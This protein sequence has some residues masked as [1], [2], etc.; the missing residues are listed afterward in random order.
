M[1]IKKRKL[2]RWVTGI[3]RQDDTA[4]K[5]VA[6][7]AVD[8]ATKSLRDGV[9]DADLVV[10]ASRVDIILQQLKD[11]KG[12]LKPGAVVIDV[13]STKQEIVST[14]NKSLKKNEFVGC[15]PMAG[16][17]KSGVENG[18]PDLFEGATCVLSKRHELVSAFWK[19]IGSDV[20]VLDPAFHDAL[21]AQFSHL[22]HVLAFAQAQNTRNAKFLGFNPSFKAN[23]RLAKSN[24]LVWLRIF[25]SNRA[26]LCSALRSHIQVLNEFDKA[27]STN[28]LAA[29]SKFLVKAHKN[30]LK[31]L[32]D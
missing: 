23:L 10:L 15:H 8:M 11:L 19:V 31:A 4:K 5:A 24:P 29:I 27:L 26:A 14:A 18:R 17:E 3:V 2:A 28:D 30:A 32:P 16:S 12:L 25:Q 9:K 22:P 13:G 1:A 20:V 21:A 7:K 6:F